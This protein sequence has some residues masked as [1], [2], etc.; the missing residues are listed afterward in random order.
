[1]QCSCVLCNSS[2]NIHV[3]FY[4]INVY[5]L[6]FLK[7]LIILVCF[8]VRSLRWW[9]WK[10][11]WLHFCEAL[12]L[13]QLRR[14]RRSSLI[15]DSYFSQPLVSMLN[16]PVESSYNFQLREINHLINQ[17]CVLISYSFNLPVIIILITL[18]I[19]MPKN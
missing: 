16:W 14:G 13:S 15:L 8:Q 9:S 2:N 10:L 6:S 3:H 12:I 4:R 1:M 11:L 18:K 7:L 17:T 5:S 19:T